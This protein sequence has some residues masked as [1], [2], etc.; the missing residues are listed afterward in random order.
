MNLRNSRVFYQRPGR[1][2]NFDGGSTARPARSSPKTYYTGRARASSVRA[3][4][5]ARHGTAAWTWLHAPTERNALE[6]RRNRMHFLSAST[7]RAEGVDVVPTFRVGTSAT[8]ANSEK[9]EVVKI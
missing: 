6:F 7:G 1:R 2:G 9:A 8:S 5:V 3:T 4:E